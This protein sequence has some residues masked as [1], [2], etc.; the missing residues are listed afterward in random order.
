[1]PTYP[2]I[3]AAE[4]VLE[5]AVAPL[6]GRA[7]PEPNCRG[8]SQRHQIGGASVRVDD[9]YVPQFPTDLLDLLGVIRTCVITSPSLPKTDG[10][11]VQFL[12]FL[13]PFSS[14]RRGREER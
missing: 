14:S 3:A 4:L 1:M 13:K 5:P 12:T 11:G 8:R 9:R 7:L 10:K 2:Q 6:A